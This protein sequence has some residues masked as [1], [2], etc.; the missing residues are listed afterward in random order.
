MNIIKLGE[1]FILW[2]QEECNVFTKINNFN[3]V[4]GKTEG[5]LGRDDVGNWGSSC[6]RTVHSQ[7]NL[8]AIHSRETLDCVVNSNAGVLWFEHEISS[9]SPSVWTVDSQL[10]WLFWKT[11][12]PLGQWWFSV[13]GLWPLWGQITLSQDLHIRYP[14]NQIFTLQFITVID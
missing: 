3:E 2:W 11:I 6:T 4:R 12:K 8:T 5:L 13:Y 14:A 1:N 7:S 9:I 10:M